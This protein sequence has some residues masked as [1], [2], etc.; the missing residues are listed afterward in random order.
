M[1]C[2]TS[3]SKDQRSSQGVYCASATA[4]AESAGQLREASFGLGVVGLIVGS[5]VVRVVNEVEVVVKVKVAVRVVITVVVVG[6]W[7]GGSG[8]GGGIVGGASPGCRVVAALGLWL[9]LGGSTCCDA[10][11][12]A[13]VVVREDTPGKAQLKLAARQMSNHS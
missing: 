13:D 2:T 9:G 5:A 11:A 12:G 3:Y 1:A 6:T 10:G 4:A 7:A 8:S